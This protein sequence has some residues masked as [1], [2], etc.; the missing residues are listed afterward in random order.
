MALE[1][2]GEGKPCYFL[3]PRNLNDQFFIDYPELN[4]WR[5]SSYEEFES[6]VLSQLYE[7]NG[8]FVKDPKNYCFKSN[9]VSKLIYENLIR[10]R[11]I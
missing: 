2:L 1:M 8:E 6:K 5:I 9:T 4:K 10:L 11:N 7:N 3:D